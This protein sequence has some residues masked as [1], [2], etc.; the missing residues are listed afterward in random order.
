MAGWGRNIFTVMA[1]QTGIFRFRGKLGSVVGYKSSLTKKAGESVVREHAATVSNPRT[2]AQA[3]QRAKMVPA[4][5]FYR[6]FSNV[7]D[8]AFLPSGNAF[9]NR[10][11]FMSLALK[12]AGVPNILRGQKKLPWNIPYQ[13]SAGALGL[14]SLA[15]MSE[16]QL[17]ILG[18]NN[19]AL[20]MVSAIVSGDYAAGMSE[21]RDVTIAQFSRDILAGNP[22]LQEG[23]EIDFLAIMADEAGNVYP[24]NAF[25]VLDTTDVVTTIGDKFSAFL[26][27]SADDQFIAIA[28]ANGTHGVAASACIIS[29]RTASSWIYTNS[30]LAMG[31]VGDNLIYYTDDEVIRSYMNASSSAESD[32]ILQQADN[33]TAEGLRVV[34]VT[35][36]QF[37]R[38]NAQEGDVQSANKCVVA[39]MSDG[40]RR[41]VVLSLSEPGLQAYTNNAYVNITFT[42]DGHT[43]RV[44]LEDTNLS[45]M[46]PISLS[47]VAS[48]TP[49][50]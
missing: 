27:V 29:S 6:A 4:Q 34:G 22:Q 39:I 42:R 23:Y 49:G 31:M 1:K 25:V 37:T 15:V 26:P 17:A 50:A 7:L 28:P 10:T 35:T 44:N 48:F 32:K 2:Y 19:P 36:Y 40:S 24:A 47:Q 9:R 45:G 14:D 43:I 16:N 3:T 21:A 30:F 20:A 5:D 13:V 18:L 33:S 8:H 41:P 12:T 11:A 46:K 38:T